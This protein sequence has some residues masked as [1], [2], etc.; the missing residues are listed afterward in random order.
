VV[1]PEWLEHFR[2]ED[3]TFRRLEPTE[4]ELVGGWVSVGKRL[5][6]DAV[7]GRIEWLAFHRPEV[8]LRAPSEAAPHL[9]RLRARD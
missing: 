3:A 9:A 8:V 6:G 2:T 7:E 5:M 4:T 1:L